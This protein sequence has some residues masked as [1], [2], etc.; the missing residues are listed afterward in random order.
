MPTEAGESI[1]PIGPVIAA[2]LDERFDELVEAMC[3]A[4]RAK[5]TTYASLRD[6]AGFRASVARTARLYAATLSTGHGIPDGAVTALQVV[7]AERC[8]QGV[9]EAEMVDAVR[10]A[11]RA[12][13]E[14]LIR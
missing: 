6:R 8:R 11:A 4:V 1:L 10:W 13:S 14:F 7:G 12:G 5:S 9:P 2:V 3:E